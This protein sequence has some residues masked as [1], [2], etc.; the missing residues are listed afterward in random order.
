MKKTPNR[1]VIINAIS[2]GLLN[3]I[4]MIM[5]PVYSYLLGAEVY[6]LSSVYTTGVTILST[7]IGLET[8]SSIGVAQKDFLTKEQLKF[9]ANGFYIGLAM[10]GTL[11]SVS[12]LFLR[13]LS[14]LLEIPWWTVLL[15]CPHAFGVFCVGLLNSK[16]TYEFKQEKN[17]FVSVSMSLGTA[18]ISVIAILLFPAEKRFHGKVIGVAVPYI[19]CSIILLLYFLNKVGLCIQKK[20]MEYMLRYSTPLL[21]SSLCVQL[22]S[23]MDKL[24]LQKMESNSAVGIYSLTFNFSAVISSIWYALNHAW[25]PFYYQ[26]EAANNEQD[27]LLHSQKYTRLFSILVI[28]FILLSP[29][30][31]PIFCAPEFHVGTLMIP[32][33]VMGFYADFLGCFARNHQY[34]YKQT[35]VIAR[36]SVVVS[37]C[38]LILNALFIPRWGAMGAAL[39]TMAAQLL[40]CGSHWLF[41]I[42]RSVPNKKYPYRLRMFV[43]YLLLI[44]TSVA[45]FYLPGTWLIRW[46]AGCILGVWLLS[47]LIKEKQIF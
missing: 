26:Y 42:Y 41:A 30:I 14:N 15:L 1:V 43:P 3:G 8:S 38:N 29:E 22:F 44:G 5:M 45:L 35:N 19:F 16:F 17:L 27:L 7:I 23:G 34:Y 28:G 10:C 36:I 47:K 33:F 24:M 32:I 2:A 39:A 46:S 9:Q 4:S 13:P 11:T 6:G 12:I 25:T 31:F 40:S 20:Y 21:F 37:L 18:L